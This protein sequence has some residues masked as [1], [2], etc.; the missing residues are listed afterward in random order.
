MRHIPL[1]QGKFA[2]V[3]DADF[4]F[5]SQF[6]WYIHK[7]RAVR[8]PRTFEGKRVGLIWMHRVIMRP[9]KS[10]VV[11]HINGNK[12]DNR[13]INLRVCSKSQNEWNKPAYK[14]NTTGMKNV[15]WNKSKQRYVVSFSKYRKKI[16]VGQ[17][18]DFQEAVKARN[19]HVIEIHE[20]FNPVLRVSTSA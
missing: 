5:L 3:D 11:D 10:M 9:P 13:R 17:F 19:E 1:S 12:L 16:I 6:K 7:G 2:I 20:G 8:K 18:S 15:Y 14:T 4:E